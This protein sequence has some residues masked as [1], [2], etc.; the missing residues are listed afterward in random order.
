MTTDELRRRRAD[1]LA[2]VERLAL[3]PGDLNPAERSSWQDSTAELERIEV[4]LA[5]RQERASALTGGGV[6]RETGDGAEAAGR[7]RD[8]QVARHVDPADALA[9]AAGAGGVNTRAGGLQLADAA[10]AAIGA[11]S[12]RAD[13]P[14]SFQES[15]ERVVTGADRHARQVA[16]YVATAST[17]AYERA[18]RAWMAGGPASLMGDDA[19]EMRRV[20]SFLAERAM[21]EGSV[22][23]GQAAVPPMLDPALILTNTG[24]TSAFRQISTIKTIATQTWRGITSA[25]VVANWSQEAAEYTDGS[26]TLTSP[27]ISPV[28]MDCYV[29]ASWELVE[30]SSLAADIG[31]LF[32]DARDRLEATAFA[33][34]TGSTQPRGLITVLQ[35]TTASRVDAQTNGAYGAVDV[36]N[37]DSALPARWRPNASWMANQTYWN[38]TRQFALGGSP[39]SAFWVD[40]GPGRPASLLGH[41]VYESSAMQ[42]TLSSATA[43]SDDILVLGDFRSGYFIVDR[44]PTTIMTNP[45]V[46]GSN[47]RP[48][49]EMGWALYA[50][51]GGDCVVADAF[52]MLRL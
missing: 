30:D 51:V 39:Q 46:I 1:L 38:R 16:E 12:D 50:R 35:L 2:R 34:G 40:F 47:R 27:T 10:R 13:V 14:A 26:P 36:F 17:S 7:Y 6:V 4:Q 37:V 45:M 15:A 31:M 3:T 8:V 11:W 18:W 29:Q 32:G 33:V 5:E 20:Q 21:N 22:G 52:R 19:L 41:A 48:T 23:A 43:S 25:G 28:R 42:S 24:A 49:G 9:R 44:V